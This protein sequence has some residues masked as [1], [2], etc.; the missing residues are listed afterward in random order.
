MFA[1]VRLRSQ[2]YPENTITKVFLNKDVMCYE[3]CES[4][5][6]TPEYTS[7]LEKLTRELAA[8]LGEPLPERDEIYHF[9]SV[10]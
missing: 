6:F 5:L 10:S 8:L 3:G 1:D 2:M 4:G 9:R 7:Y